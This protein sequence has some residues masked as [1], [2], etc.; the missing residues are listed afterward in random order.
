MQLVGFRRADG[1]DITLSHNAKVV[2]EA[3]S[4]LSSEIADIFP[5]L[6]GSY[7]NLVA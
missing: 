2:G 3:L 6:E 1:I 4:R 5:Q 7:T